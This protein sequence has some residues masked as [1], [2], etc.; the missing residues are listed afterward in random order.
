LPDQASLVFEHIGRAVRN[1]RGDAQFRNLVEEATALDVEILRCARLLLFDAVVDEILARRY[2]DHRDE[3]VLILQL[4]GEDIIDETVAGLD[5]V[6][7]AADRATGAKS[8]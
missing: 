2:L 6:A 3:G 1:P 7:E 5:L 8:R 4:R